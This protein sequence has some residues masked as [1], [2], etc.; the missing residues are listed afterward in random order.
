METEKG[1]H[2]LAVQQKTTG[3]TGHL[4]LY[5]DDLILI[6]ENEEILCTK[7]TKWKSGIEVEDIKMNIRKQ[8]NV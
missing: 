4:S 8:N 7:V 5:A 6:A 1:C 2:K 3:W